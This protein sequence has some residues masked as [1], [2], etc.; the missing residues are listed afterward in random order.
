MY[1]TYQHQNRICYTARSH[2]IIYSNYI[3]YMGEDGA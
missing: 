3:S 1:L 2:I